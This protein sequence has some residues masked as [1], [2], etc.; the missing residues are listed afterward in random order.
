LDSG[1]NTAVAWKRRACSCTVN[2][3]RRL[4]T[5][6][7]APLPPSPNT[8]QVYLT[9]TE[10]SAYHGQGQVT[11]TPVHSEERCNESSSPTLS[12][13]QIVPVPQVWRASSDIGSVSSIT[14]AEED[15]RS[16]NHWGGWH[17]RLGNGCARGGVQRIRTAK[18]SM[19]QECDQGSLLS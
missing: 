2:Q 14:R 9:L 6:A 15:C 1:N 7:S 5:P 16:L 4:M 12:T 8:S 17:F 19:K 3:G 18:M 13:E 10:A 11:K